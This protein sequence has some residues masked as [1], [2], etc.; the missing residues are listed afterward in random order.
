MTT[1]SIWCIA[2]LG[3][4]FA[5]PAAA[6]EAPPWDGERARALAQQLVP[7]TD[8]LFDSFFKQPR[9]PSTPRSVRDYE[10][11]DR[12][13][14][15]LRNQAKSLAAGLERGEGREGTRA[16]FESLMVTV[17]WARERAQSVFT[18]QDV[19]ERARA[20]GELLEQLAPLYGTRAPA[21]D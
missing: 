19:A 8:A 12:D 18:T 1:R 20:V 11:L 16:S 17:R 7:A 15:R 21:A 6:D 3:I 9:P 5:G 4:C 10:R 14:R 13:I 2:L